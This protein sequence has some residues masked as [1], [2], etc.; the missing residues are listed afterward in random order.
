VAHRKDHSLAS[1]PYYKRR[2]TVLQ[3][4]KCNTLLSRDVLAAALIGDI[5]EFQRAGA[6]R[7]LPTWTEI[8]IF[9]RVEFQMSRNGT[10]LERVAFEFF[11][12]HVPTWHN[13]PVSINMSS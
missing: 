2:S 3:C 11:R 1:A 8:F 5:F 6:T 9:L 4:V 7:N 10:Y 12:I 13:V